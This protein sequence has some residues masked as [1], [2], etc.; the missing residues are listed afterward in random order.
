VPV[1]TRRLVLAVALLLG[2]CAPASAQDW[3][4]KMFDSLE[5]DFGAVARGAKVE[6]HF[7]I[8]NLYKEDVHIVGVRSS[9]GCTTPTITKDTLKTYEESELV[10]QFNT[11]SFRG[12][13]KATLTVT[14]DKPFYA[15]VQVQVRGTIRS[16][17]VLEPSFIDLGTIPHGTEKSQTITVTHTGNSDWQI[18]DVRTS[19]DHISAALEEA[20]RGGGHVAYHLTIQLGPDAPVGFIREQL[21]LVTNDRQVMQIPVEVEGRVEADVTV[22]PASLF[23]GVLKPGQKVTKQIVVKGRQEFRILKVDCPDAG[24]S[25]SPKDEAKTVHVIPVTFTAPDAP[26]KVEQQVTIETDLGEGAVPVVT[27]HATVVGDE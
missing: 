14:I 8:T 13:R 2:V 10:A 16:D 23:M 27:V 6:R 21:L 11:T 17:I 19:N 5:H 3:A 24:F 4:R 12:D 9:C 7:K 22:S 1:T 20:S 26:G 25:F 18:A 15:Q